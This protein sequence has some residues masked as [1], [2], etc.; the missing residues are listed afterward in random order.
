MYASKIV[1]WFKIWYFLIFI[2][3]LGVGGVVMYVIDNSRYLCQVCILLYIMY[4][5]FLIKI[6][7]L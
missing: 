3:N 6:K 5:T 4:V 2:E 1:K 7:C